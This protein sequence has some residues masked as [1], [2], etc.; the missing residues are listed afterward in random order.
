[1][2]LM[3][4]KRKNIYLLISYSIIIFVL[5]F[6]IL[7]E[8]DIVVVKHNLEKGIEANVYIY[9]EINIDNNWSKN[10]SY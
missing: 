10:N 1:M 4:A 2:Y 8:L 5:L 9:S 6:F 7:P 3:Q